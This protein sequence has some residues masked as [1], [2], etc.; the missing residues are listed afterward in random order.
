MLST[1]DVLFLLSNQYCGDYQKMIHAMK[2]KRSVDKEKLEELYQKTKCHFVTLLD[3]DY[4]PILKQVTYPPLILYYYGDLSLL[5]KPY[6]MTAIGCR[7]P[8]IYQSDMVHR[9]IKQTEEGLKNEA[10]IVSGMAKGIDSIAMRA[11]MQSKAKV[12]AISGCGIDSFYPKESQDI[13][14]YCKTDGLVL[15]EYPFDIEPKPSN[16]VF[17]NRL[18]VAFG[19]ILFVGA[20]SEKSGT[21]SSVTHALNMNKEIFA[22]PCNIGENNLCNILIKEGASPVLCA[23]DL[24]DALKQLNEIEV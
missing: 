4:P 7:N 14:E 8:T 18:L 19:K 23:K 12:V 5:S 9:L 3:D 20:G 15:S 21:S 11:A 16:F 22:L 6:R 13:Y 1:R 17:R 10:V 24:I 2:E